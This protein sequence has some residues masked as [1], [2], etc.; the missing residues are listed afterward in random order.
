[1][2]VVAVGALAV[3]DRQVDDLQV[4]LGGAEEQVEVA[5]R[6]EVAEV[7][8]V[9]G[10]ALVVGLAQSTLVPQSV[11]LIGWPSSQEKA[12]LKN[13]LPSRLRKRIACSSIG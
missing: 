2:L 5:E 6:I 9:G 13:L 4:Q 3:A 7:G 12:R 1:M 11:S 10:D 8:A